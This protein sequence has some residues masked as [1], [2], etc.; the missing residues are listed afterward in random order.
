MLVWIYNIKQIIEKTKNYFLKH[1]HAGSVLKGCQGFS[2]LVWKGNDFFIYTFFLYTADFKPDTTKQKTK[3]IC[4]FKEGECQELNLTQ[5][6]AWACNTF[7][8]TKCGN[9]ILSICS[10]AR[11]KVFPAQFQFP[12]LVCGIPG[13]MEL[14]QILHLPQTRC[15]LLPNA[16]VPLLILHMITYLL[17]NGM[18]YTGHSEPLNTGQCQIIWP[19]VKVMKIWGYR[20]I[21][22]IF[23]LIL[24]WWESAKM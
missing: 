6:D 20:Y 12:A 10:G 4:S 15:Q 9:S 24:L 1:F 19:R 3:I 13:A 18:T 5:H 11:D 23:I 22:W 2:A 21:Q 16:T 14:L 8:P 17:S 7:L